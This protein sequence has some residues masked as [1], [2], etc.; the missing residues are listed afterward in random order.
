VTDGE[1]SQESSGGQQAGPTP[2][3]GQPAGN[4][5]KAPEEM[6]VGELVFEVSDRA[7]VLIREEI[8]LAKTEVTE[9]FNRLLRGSVAG[10]AAGI[11]ALLALLLIMHGV[12]WLL[13]D[14]VFDNFWAG[15]FVEAALFLLIGAAA[16]LFAWRSFKRGAP[17]TPDMAIEEAKEIK[18][19]FD[20]GDGEEEKA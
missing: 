7:S 15:F 10:L 8:E 3:A 17:P 19:A 11:F 6:S 13:N 20:G 2:Q 16:G 14:L 1:S 5:A 9:K 12:A 18:A 4:G